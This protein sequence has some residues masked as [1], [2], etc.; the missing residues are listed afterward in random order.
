MGEEQGTLGIQ[1]GERW[2]T[3]GALV[4]GMKYQVVADERSGRYLGMKD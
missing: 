1:R 3:G 2:G 4:G